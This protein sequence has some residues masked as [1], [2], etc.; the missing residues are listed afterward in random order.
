MFEN[1]KICFSKYCDF[2]GRARRSEYWYFVLFNFIVGFVIGLIVGIICGITGNSENAV[3]ISNVFS[4]I[5]SLI[6]LL[7]GLGVCVRRL[8]DIGKSGWNYLFVLIPIIGWILLIVW[9]CQDSQPGTNKWG[10]NPKGF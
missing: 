7:P 5:W 10:A 3:K 4:R 2:K 9:F 6:V 8:H 1:V